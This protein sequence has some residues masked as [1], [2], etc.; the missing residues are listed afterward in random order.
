MKLKLNPIYWLFPVL[1]VLNSCLQEDDTGSINF[2]DQTFDLDWGTLF[3]YQEDFYPDVYVCR[4]TL[5][6]SA[7]KYNEEK[8]EPEGIGTMLNVFLLSETGNVADGI[9]RFSP[10]NSKEPFTLIEGVALLVH[11]NSEDAGTGVLEIT[12]GTVTLKKTGESEYD[13]VF[14][15]TVTDY[16]QTHT[17]AAH[18][19]GVLKSV[20]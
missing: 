7:I 13:I 11:D 18:Y 6:S 19:K 4:I 9:Y 3:S 16:H 1:L 20:Q 15:I 17:L 14:G 8:G 10:E 12:S 5:F 2:E